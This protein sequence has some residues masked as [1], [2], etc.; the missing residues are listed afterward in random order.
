[1]L[2]S[3]SATPSAGIFPDSRLKES[4]WNRLDSQ[5][6]LPAAL[7]LTQTL[8]S[9]AS[10]F[11]IERIHL[12]STRLQHHLPA[13]PALTRALPDDAEPISIRFIVDDARKSA[14]LPSPWGWERYKREWEGG[15]SAHTHTHTHKIIIKSNQ[16]S[17]TRKQQRGRALLNNRITDAGKSRHHRR[18]RRRLR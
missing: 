13:A 9:I 10:G 11:P 2:P 3:S 12:E 18:W 6:H 16:S 15:N 1:M 5:H 14:A 8:P 17:S 7:A 4:T